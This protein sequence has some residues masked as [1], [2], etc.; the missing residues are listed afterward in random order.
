[1]NAVAVRRHRLL[2]L[3]W[4]AAFI[5]WCLA[6]A[7]LVYGH[8]GYDEAAMW[9]RTL[10]WPW[11]I[12]AAVVVILALRRPSQWAWTLVG[13]ITAVHTGLVIWTW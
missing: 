2:V 12:A 8:M 11:V 10:S 5:W 1:M 6:G 4:A 3:L 7:A 13:L 9:V